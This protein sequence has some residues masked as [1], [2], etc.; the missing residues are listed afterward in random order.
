MKSFICTDINGNTFII[1]DDV[2]YSLNFGI[3]LS[4]ERIQD[5]DLTAMKMLKNDFCDM[6]CIDEIASFGTIELTG[7]SLQ[8]AVQESIRNMNDEELDKNKIINIESGFDEDKYY[9]INNNV[10]EDLELEDTNN[11]TMANTYEPVRYIF[12]DTV[13]EA[14][15]IFD[16][17]TDII[18]EQNINDKIYLSP[19]L[20]PDESD[21]NT[22][23][24]DGNC[25]S[26]KISSIVKKING[27][28]YKQITFY[29]DGSL[30]TQNFGD[31]TKNYMMIYV[32]GELI[33]EEVQK[34]DFCF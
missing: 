25:E 32:N 24:V 10:N 17:E 22:M 9:M 7:D 19:I 21:Y 23:I 3:D 11:Y 30:K 4:V 12:C 2:Y 8:G 28:N 18:N 29:T 16:C 33:V 26:T 13:V 6:N 20:Y 1:V 31:V 34:R 14:E 15:P 27:Y 5:D